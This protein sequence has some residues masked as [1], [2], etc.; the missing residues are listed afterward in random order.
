MQYFYRFFNKTGLRELDNVH[1]SRMRTHSPSITD[2]IVLL[3]IV[4]CGFYCGCVGQCVSSIICHKVYTGEQSLEGSRAL[5]H[6]GFC[7]CI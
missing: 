2:E 3:Y 7:D 1:Y 6:T 4:E 5:W